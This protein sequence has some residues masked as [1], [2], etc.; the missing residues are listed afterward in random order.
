MYFICVLRHFRFLNVDNGINSVRKMASSKNSS[1]RMSRL[2]FPIHRPFLI[3]VAGGTASGKSSVCAKIVEQLGQADIDHKQRQ[4]TIIGQD[5]FYKNLTEEEAKKADKGE[6]NFDHPDAFDFELTM[7]TM[8]A[9]ASNKTVEVPS[10][11][12]ITNKRADTTHRIYPADVI[13]FE[14]ILVFYPKELRDMFHMKLFVDT[15]PDTRLSRR[16]LR[17]IQERGRTLENIIHQY[18]TLVKPA[19]EEF[20][21]PTKKYA[22]VIIPR[23]ADNTVAIDLIVQHIQELMRPPSVSKRSRHNSDSFVGRPH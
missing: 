12:Y 22:D 5:S 6:F 1:P 4:V 17:D 2:D 23:G 19:F 7:K 18:T 16:V 3:G 21:L 9:I 10:Y 13:L 20:C 14:G 8:K 11:N 15:D